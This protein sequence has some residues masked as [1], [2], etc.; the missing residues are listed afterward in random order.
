MERKG[1]LMLA[2]NNRS[3]TNRLAEN[4]V[5]KNKRQFLILFLTIL[6]SS[7]MLFSIFTIGL[8]YLDLSRLQNTRLYGSEYD[9]AVMNGFTEDQKEILLRHAGIESVGELAYCGTVKSSDS[10]RTVNA[11]FLWGDNT[12][13]ESQ[14]APAVTE[15]KGRYPQARNELLA[16]EEVLEACGKRSLSVGGRLSLTYE[17]HAGIH[18]A[19]FVISGIWKGYGGD[20]ANFYVSE[21]F[22][23]QTGYDLKSGGILQ[24]KFKSS[25]VTG[26]TIENL[27]ESLGLSSAQVFQASE[28]IERSLTILFAVLGLCFMICLSAYLLIYN[29][30]YLSVSGKIRYYGLLQTLG[31]TKRQLVRLIRKQIWMVAVTGIM[32]GIV[33]G[34]SVSLLLV[35]YAV[36]VLGISLGN[37]GLCFYPEVLALSIF[38]TVLAV[39]CGVRKPVHIAAGVTPVEAVKYRGNMEFP[40]AEKN[41]QKQKKE[42]GSLYWRMAEGQLKNNRKR[43]AVVFLSLAASLIVFFCLTTLIDSQGRR[44]VYPNY[45]DADF[46]VH[47][48]AQ[49]TEDIASLQPAIDDAFLSDIQE[50]DGV[51][52][53]HAVKGIPV[54]FPYEENGF[55]D[56]WI[57]GCTEMKPYLTYSDTAAE[58]QQNPEK[59][60]GM[61]KGIDESE[62]DYLNES[63]GGI[64]DRQEFLCGKTAILQYA[65]FEIPSKWIGNSISFRLPAGAS[66]LRFGRRLTCATGAQ[67]PVIHAPAGRGNSFAV[68]QEITIGAVSYEDYYGA[69]VN[70]GANL[71]VSESYLE[72]LTSRPYVLSLNI[73]YKRSCDAGTEEEIK[74]IIKSNPYDNDLLFISKY[75]DMKTIRDSQS[76]MFETGTVISLLLLLVGMLNYINTMANSMQ[77]RKLTFSIMESVGMSRKQIK[78][79]LI[80]EGMLYAGGSVF[81]TLTIGTGI[82]WFI[83]QSMN[84]MKIPFSIPV[85]PLLCAIL[86]V[87]IICVLTPIVTYKRTVR[88][89]PVTERL[90][91]Y[92]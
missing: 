79:L 90:R 36:K 46:I 38:V 47:N 2:N 51:A 40:H 7:F 64:I 55:S 83:F 73:K 16:T 11:G 78:K 54:I 3:V 19:D 14:K 82:T 71:I 52:E 75:D 87:V 8:T 72:S 12:Y 77:N 70:C 44:T 18:A 22:Y 81:I 48:A 86:L 6:L 43:T 61:I 20:K 24:V 33:L 25:C 10:D 65:G 34:I 56:F 32:A 23:E 37:T 29:I 85:L 59:Y 62:F 15:M 21:D 13:W 68:L 39:V 74:N 42:R 26:K 69:T 30:L 1:I 53:V 28:Y 92:E 84:Y 5:R 76:G 88:N 63:L 49:T 50:T 17:D 27:R 91:E 58:Y 45:W 89:R 57:K 41:R 35:P 9:I 67:R 60:Y 80:H 31:M 4:T 66:S